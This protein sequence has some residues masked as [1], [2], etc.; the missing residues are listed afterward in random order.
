MV[1]QRFFFYRFATTYFECV[2]SPVLSSKKKNSKR[3]EKKKRIF[4]G[5]FYDEND[6]ILFNRE[7]A[8][9]PTTK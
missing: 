9:A 6:I 8:R 4:Y 5:S 7:K 2:S 3:N 1:L